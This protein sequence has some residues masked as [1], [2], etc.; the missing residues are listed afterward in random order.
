MPNSESRAANLRACCGRPGRPWWS[1]RQT[2]GDRRRPGAPWR[3]EKSSR[4]MRPPREP[5]RCRIRRPMNCRHA[6]FSKPHHIEQG[7]LDIHRIPQVGMLVELHSHQQTAVG[8][9]L[10]PKAPRTRDSARDE[11]LGD[12]GKVIIDPL[13][14]GLQAPP[15]AMPVRIPRRPGC[16]PAR[17]RRPSRARASRCFPNSGVSPRPGTRRRHTGSSDCSH[18][19]SGNP[20]APRSKD[21]GAILGRRFQLLS[22]FMRCVELGWQRLHF[23]QCVTQAVSEPQA[24][25]LQEPETLRNTS[26]LCRSVSTMLIVALSGRSRRFEVHFPWGSG[27]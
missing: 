12:R 9:P 1:S 4:G 26:L 21:L 3:R 13:A 15:R 18:P 2:A 7:H 27:R 23:G 22:H 25:R 19:A 24:D 14:V 5:R 11:V 16:S 8:S 20:D 17:R 6:I 10:D